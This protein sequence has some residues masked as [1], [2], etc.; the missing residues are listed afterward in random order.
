MHQQVE[1][2]LGIFRG[3]PRRQPQGAL[4]ETAPHR[5][6]QGKGRGFG[7]MWAQHP[8]I[9]R[10]LERLLN[11]TDVVE[12]Q[13]Q[14]MGRLGMVRRGGQQ[15]ALKQQHLKKVAVGI[16]QLQNGFDQ[17]HDFF[18]RRADFFDL[19]PNLVGEVLHPLFDRSFEQLFFFVEI[20]IDRALGDL[21]L[22]RYAINGRPL[23]AVPRHHPTRRVQDFPDAELA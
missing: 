12:V 18:E 8:G 14:R 19:G 3:G 17:T 4:L 1:Q 20:Q 10:L 9:D 23:K 13:I 11:E 5:L 21:G 7:V 16:A 2:N 15:V 6:A 22:F